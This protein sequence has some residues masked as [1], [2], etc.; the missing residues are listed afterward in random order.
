MAT[1]QIKLEPVIEVMHLDFGA[2]GTASERR[3]LSA[4]RTPSVISST[5]TRQAAGVVE[6][7]AGQ[8]LQV[9][10]GSMTQAKALYIECRETILVRL[11]SG[12]SDPITVAPI[13]TGA[14][15]FLLLTG[16]PTGLW[17]ENEAATAVLVSFLAVGLE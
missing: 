1:I 3:G 14:P 5:L 16:A 6:V 11:D 4:F 13:D 10:F 9:S 7:A 17:I 12:A 8:N 2:S 15:G